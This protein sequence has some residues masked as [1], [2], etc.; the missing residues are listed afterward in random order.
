MRDS[1]ENYLNTENKIEI[2]KNNL[3]KIDLRLVDIFSGAFDSVERA[4]AGIIGMD[5]SFLRMRD[6][7]QQFWD[8]LVA[9]AKKN[10]PKN[11]KNNN[12]ELKKESHWAAIAIAITSNENNIFMVSNLDSLYGIHT[13]LS[14]N[15]KNDAFSENEKFEEIEISWIIALYDICTSKIIKS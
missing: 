9:I 8:A 1:L 2:I 13:E 3:I 4:K 12:Y 15:L 11:L 7:I 6:T 14:I 5:Q 10:D